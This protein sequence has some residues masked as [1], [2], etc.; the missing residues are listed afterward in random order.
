[1]FEIQFRKGTFFKNMIELVFHNS[2]FVNLEFLE[3]GLMIYSFNADGNFLMNFFFE[4]HKFLTYKINEEYV[5]QLPCLKVRKILQSIEKDDLLTI[6]RTNN[7][8]IEFEAKN[9]KR[10]FKSTIKSN[11]SQRFNVQHPTINDYENFLT[12]E[13]AY[14]TKAIKDLIKLENIQIMF[15]CYENRF[16]IRSGDNE[17]TQKQYH[18]ESG[19]NSFCQKC[20]VKKEISLQVAEV[21][22]RINN[23][24]P[25]VS[26]LFSMP[27]GE[28]ITI[29]LNMNIGDI[30]TFN[31]F[32][33]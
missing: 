31:M 10:T 1:M 15:E 29:M 13:T 5:T 7:V 16:S 27:D 23:I 28:S 21:L 26:I 33:K 8:L 24:N 17:L 22:K 9:T 30:G 19:I 6:K 4:K 18:F 25:N 3:K 12:F 32:L 11:D 20:L 14:I 2:T